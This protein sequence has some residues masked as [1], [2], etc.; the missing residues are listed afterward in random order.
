[1]PTIAEAHIQLQP[2]FKGGRAAI[3][4]E[5]GKPLEQEAARATRSVNQGLTSIG[6]VGLA[7]AAG[8][9]VGLFGAASAAGD[10]D[11]AIASNVQVLG[12]AS[13]A[14]QEFAAAGVENVG[15]S[16]TAVLNAATAFGQLAKVAG[17]TGTEV[18][19]FGIDMVTMAADLAAFA[20]VPADQ[21]VNDLRSAFAGSAETMQKYNV[22]LNESE[23]KAALFRAT[24]EQ[25]T[26]TLTAQQ[27]ILGTH[28]AL[29]EQTGDIQGQA[30]REAGSFQRS[31]DNLKATI[32]NIAAD[33]GGPIVGFAAS[34]MSTVSGGLTTLGEWNEELGGMLGVGLSAGI[35]IAAAGAAAF[36]AVGKVKSAVTA[37]QGL[38]KA[39]QL[40]TGALGLLALAV[41]AGFL[42]YGK[43]SQDSRETAARTKE[44]GAALKGTTEDAWDYAAALAGA[45]GQIDGFAIAQQ[46]LSRALIDTG[47][48][49]EKLEQALG[50][51]GQQADNAFS[52]LMNQAN[53]PIQSMMDLAMA[54]GVSETN[55]RLL[56]E[57][58][59]EMNDASRR[60][61]GIYDWINALG[62]GDEATA[63][64]LAEVGPLIPA[65]EE[66]EDQANPDVLA[67]MAT[68]FLN[69]ATAASES[70]E[71]LVD[72]AEA[73]AASN[74][75][76]DSSTDTYN[77]LMGLLGEMTEE[78][79]NA[80]LA[81][82]DLGDATT[83][84]ATGI[85]E[86]A[87]VSA[88][89]VDTTTTLDEAMGKMAETADQ[90]S[91]AF[92]RVIGRVLDV[93]DANRAF[94]EGID[95]LTEALTE[96]GNTWDINTDAGRA[97]SEALS[98]SVRDILNV[99]DAQIRAGATTEEATAE[100]MRQRDVLINEVAK[101]LGITTDEA[102]TYVNQLGLTPESV[103]TSIMLAGQAAAKKD[104]E[105][106]LARLGEIPESEAT[107]IQALID[108]GD[109]AAADARL[110]VLS[111][112]RWM[113]LH[114]QSVFD[115]LPSLGGF[116][117]FGS[118]MG[119][120]FDRPAVTS[121]AEDGD[122]EVVLTLGKPG[123]LA[124]QLSD[125]RVLDPIL[126][127]L[128]L[129]AAVSGGRRG[130]GFTLVHHGQTVTPATVSAAL[131]MADL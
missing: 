88:D 92:D 40:G 37:F 129:G 4:R 109:Y 107:A 6:T 9:G 114:I 78:E 57:G 32:T 117:I 45:D 41:T 30:A 29:M 10:L 17:L 90:L 125:R 33:F 103:E 101:A 15:L 127:A 121:I 81:A 96:N 116:N 25:V 63:A 85:E 64:L 52:I 38:S 105:D 79:R 93:G 42:I 67:D 27:R 12:D 115:N 77:E 65:L 51:I 89:T 23:I 50:A 44:V 46:A 100:M 24:G 43:L 26:G 21:A 20:N 31:I 104:V 126:D 106:H 71:A 108:E 124:K 70:A 66:I 54:A 86:M 60:N 19:D 48:E 110:D 36:A 99:A 53:D 118:A 80:A 18:S 34:L 119:N 122:P 22:F 5:F 73:R 59:L 130:D 91:E 69:S 8:L 82:L 58:M 97:N 113:T 84:A 47:D 87:N 2:S 111:A 112:A 49:G 128:P 55:A 16:E 72:E 95:T 14:V 76:A 39:A 131:Q 94:E 68:E 102:E 74:D 35:G 120:Y 61:E 83:E 13:T 7:A 11:A 62:L 56:A 75:V 1:M 28:A 3:Q 98:S 123:N